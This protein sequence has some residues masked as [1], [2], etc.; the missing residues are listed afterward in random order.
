MTVMPLM[1][2]SSRACTTA[3]THPQRDAWERSH[4]GCPLSMFFFRTNSLVIYIF[5]CFCC[6]IVYHNIIALSFF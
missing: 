5:L 6:S 1:T 3:G 2:T 4:T